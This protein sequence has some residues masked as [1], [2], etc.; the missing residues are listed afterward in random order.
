MSDSI[1][2][3]IPAR[4][5]SKGLPDKNI[6]F[7]AGHP[8]IAYSIAAAKLT[9]NINRVIVSTDSEVY[10]EIAKKY[11][12]D[13]P[14]L[15]PV[16]LAGDRSTDL[17][18]FQHAINWLES[19]EKMVP[20]LFVHLRPTTPLR[21]PVLIR[22]AI[23]E[24][25]SDSSATSLR[26]AHKASESPLKWFKRDEFG[27]FTTMQGDSNLEA[28]NQ[29]RQDFADIFVPDGYVDIVRSKLIR[30]NNMLHGNKVIGF[31]SPYC[32]EIDTEEEFEYLEYQ[33]CKTGSPLKNYLDNKY[34]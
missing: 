2:A 13:V 22:N 18:F 34:D 30:Q 20:D 17:E 3:I 27:Y 4:K 19:N 25:I 32:V 15:R 21:D 23:A 10:A 8:L 12:A 26:S 7:L 5:G 1:L 33:I 9:S 24:I 6:K 16:E 28:S 31:E 11:G 29:R 14:F